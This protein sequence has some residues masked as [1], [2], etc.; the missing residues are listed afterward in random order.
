M[1][2]IYV[3]IETKFTDFPKLFEKYNRIKFDEILKERRLYYYILD[4]E[5]IEGIYCACFLYFLLP[6][7]NFFTRNIAKIINL[8]N[9][10]SICYNFWLIFIFLLNSLIIR[11]SRNI[12]AIKRFLLNSNSV[13]SCILMKSILED[14][15][16]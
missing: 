13:F 14:L 4:S 1:Y 15:H 3:I 7:N 10:P 2:I 8:K 6:V 5:K 9:R 11:K 16:F 12:C